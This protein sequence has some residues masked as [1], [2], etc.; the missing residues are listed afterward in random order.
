MATISFNTTFDLTG[1]P[2]IFTLEDTADYVGQGI[3]LADVNGVFNITSPSGIVIYNNTDYSNGGCDVRNSV[4]RENQQVIQLPLAADGFP[5]VGA[6][7]IVYS[8]YDSNLTVYSTVTNTYTYEYVSPEVAIT[9]TVDCVS[10]LFTSTDA[11]N[12]VVNST[13]PT[14]IVRQHLLQFPLG[15]GLSTLTSASSVITAG[16][17]G[18][19]NGTQSTQITSTLTYVFSDELIILDTVTAAQ[20]VVVDCTYICAVYCGLRSIEQ[21]MVAAQCNPSEYSR[22][23]MLFAQLMALAQLAKLAIECGKPTDVTGYLD[24]MREI[25]NFTDD[26]SCGSSEAGLVTGLGGAG[27]TTVVESGDSVVIVTPV[28]VGTTTT[29]TVTLSTGFIASVTGHYNTVVAA[30]TNITSI[31]DSGIVAGVRTFTVNAATQTIAIPPIV[32]SNN[33]TSV[34]TSGAGTDPLM[35]YTIPADTLATNGDVIEIDASYV[36]SATTQ[37]KNI[38]FT[39]GGSNFITKLTP[40]PAS[41]TIL[42]PPDTKYCKVKIAITR[43]SLLAVYITIDTMT[44]SNNYTR[45]SG[46]NFDEGTGAGFAVADLSVNPLVFAC[47]GTNYDATSN[48]ETIT[49]N[50]L[51]VKYFEK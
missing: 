3:A 11:T 27:N 16:F 21:Q 39:L 29:Y 20:E 23:Q 50:Q 46:Y 14:S 19:A 32:L 15:S 37:D 12:Y 30:G 7:T 5:E 9:Q 1:T 31:A 8:V 51:M 38:S 48:T 45:L 44:S 25:G 36:M 40:S 13:S 22:L 2:K 26:C 6:Y 43:I 17:E 28:T 49:Q 18:F 35:T 34:S 24:R 10:P 42:L 47:F 4:S 41:N 33:L